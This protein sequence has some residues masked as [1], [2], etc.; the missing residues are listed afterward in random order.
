MIRSRALAAVLLAAMAT[1]FVTT[2]AFAGRGSGMKFHAQSETWISPQ[3]GW[4]LGAADCPAGSCTVTVGSTNGG[5]S[6]KTLGSIAAP[7]TNEDPAGL[8]EV[9]FA[10][11]LHGWAFQPALWSTSDGGRSW[12]QDATP[13]GKPVIALAADGQV[14]YMA[15]SGCDFEQGLPDCKRGVTLWRLVPGQTAWTQVSLR[16]PVSIQA[17]LAVFGATAYLVIPTFDST[18]ADVLDVTTDGVHWASRAD[19]CSKPDGE[20]LSS[21]APWSGTN[22][23]FLCQG[24]IGFGYAAKRVVRSSDAAQTTS[25]AGTEPLYG[26]VSQ[27]AATPNGTLV[28]A[29]YSIG[30]WIYR[31]AG[32]QTWTDVEDLGDGGIGWNDPQFTTSQ[33][34]FVVHGPSACCGGHGVGEL[35]Q[36]LDGGLTWRQ[37]QVSPQP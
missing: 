27:L 7:L 20:Y 13:N 28:T 21:V 22:V 35:W 6:W 24:D 4:L 14:A 25:D 9:R 34:G 11:P 31:N 15:L 2:S 19:P 18:A 37:H 29:T 1:Q 10:D 32:G 8:M 23:A 33:V 12:Q 36:T 3:Q 30:S 16:L 26:I 5:T 17:S